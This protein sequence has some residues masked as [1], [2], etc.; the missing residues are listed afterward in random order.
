MSISCVRLLF[1]VAIFNLH[2]NLPTSVPVT[3]RR[4]QEACNQEFS[5]C[6]W[7][8]NTTH[9][10]WMLP[11]K[12]QWCPLMRRKL[13]RVKFTAD[14]TTTGTKY[15]SIRSHRKTCFVG[16]FMTLSV[17]IKYGVEWYDWWTVNWKGL[18]RKRLWLNRGTLRVF[19]WRA[20]ENHE[21][22][23]SA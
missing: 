12:L 10:K 11:P 5:N 6:K 8:R 13:K 3:R 2:I 4:K 18:G 23:H 17:S 1:S 15:V 21:I 20:E 19:D 22:Y 9:N 14:T 16:Y 7:G